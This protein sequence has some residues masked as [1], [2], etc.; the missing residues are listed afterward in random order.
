MW[1]ATFTGY[2]SATA[3]AKAAPAAAPTA[4]S[5]TACPER[6]S[7]PPVEIWMIP[8]DSASAKPRSAAL[9][10]SLEV[11]LMAGKAYWPSRAASSIAR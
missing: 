5:L 8:S 1:S 9:I 10:V 2:R 4:M 7:P 11:T 6:N 3:S